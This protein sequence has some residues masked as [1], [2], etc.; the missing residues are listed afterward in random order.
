MKAARD[1][2]REVTR[3]H[4]T[5]SWRLLRASSKLLGSICPNVVKASRKSGIEG[6]AF[7]ATKTIRNDPHYTHF[8]QE[9]FGKL[10]YIISPALISMSLSI[11]AC[12]NIDFYS[13][14]N[15]Q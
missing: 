1:R 8:D 2:T 12:E 9:L 5:D 11:T 6:T 10:V 7:D 3:Q 4:C 14:M 13:H 15:L